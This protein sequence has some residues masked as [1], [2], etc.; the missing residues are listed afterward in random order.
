MLDDSL[1]LFFWPAEP[2]TRP[3]GLIQLKPAPK[4]RRQG[5]YANTGRYSLTL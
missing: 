4:Q 2:L 5:F 3:L 1:H